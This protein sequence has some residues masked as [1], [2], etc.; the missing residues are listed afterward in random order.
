M[1]AAALCGG[2]RWSQS[3]LHGSVSALT[4]PDLPDL[5]VCGAAA[6]RNDPL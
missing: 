5:R 2:Q 4:G 3:H 1:R 6:Q